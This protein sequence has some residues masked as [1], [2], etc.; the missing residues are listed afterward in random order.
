MYK[1]IQFIAQTKEMLEVLD[2]PYPSITKLPK[3]IA[4]TPSYI[5]GKRSV[6]VYN[7]PTSTVKKCLPVMDSITAG[8]HIPL[9]SDVWVENEQDDPNT[10]NIRWSFE[11]I[12][13]V[14]IQKQEQMGSYPIPD[15]YYPTAFKWI[16]PWIIKTPPGW[17]CLFTHPLHSDNVPFK[18]MTS[19][20]DT[21]KFP[22][23]VNFVFFLKK[24]FS[25]LIE[26]ETPIIQVI[27]FKRND[28]K[29]EFS[30]DHVFLKQQWEKAHS[31][32][33]DRYKRFFRSQKK[34]EQGDVKKCPF[35]FLN[36]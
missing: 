23:P 27:P 24:K 36:K 28:F 35:A 11:S 1:K 15:G 26:K 22:L 30:Y 12:Q 18:C 6:D 32:F 3:W 21:D 17:S 31:V 34:Y 20:V 9:H 2:R 19:I 33:F 10:I 7:D 5:G 25:G 16:N 14:D 29:S 13:V 8:Y 4:S